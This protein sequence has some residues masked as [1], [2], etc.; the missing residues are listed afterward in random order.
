V[1]G[2]GST[3]APGFDTSSWQSP[4]DGSKS[5]FYITPTAIFGHSVTVGDI[6]SMSYW[7]NKP[8]G[9]S[10]WTLYIYTAFEGSGDTGSFYHSRLNAE[11]YITGTP[12]VDDPDNT[13]VEWSTDG[14]DTNPLEFYDVARDGGNFGSIGNDPTLAQ[15]QN[16]GNAYSWSG[17]STNNYNS[18]DVSYFSLQTGSAWAGDFSGLVDGLTITLKNG[19]TANINLEAAPEPGTWALA[20]FAGLAILTVGKK[21]RRALTK[22]T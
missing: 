6:A 3:G 8:G 1:A 4:A 7:T 9:T 14:G 5:E 18:E 12:A 13:W 16:F 15:L 20:G 17:G 22:T 11:P 10:D 2:N 19:D 21:K